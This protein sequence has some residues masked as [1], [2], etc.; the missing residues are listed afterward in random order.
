MELNDGLLMAVK[1]SIISIL[2]VMY[3]P[4][5]NV[6]IFTFGIVLADLTID[7]E[8]VKYL[9]AFITFLGSIGWMVYGVYS[10]VRGKR[11]KEKSIIELQKAEAELEKVRLQCKVEETQSKLAEHVIQVNHYEA[12]TEELASQREA[13]KAE[14]E[15]L[16]RMR[17]G[18]S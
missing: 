10:A 13:L 7:V 8:I 18:L 6:L 12:I 17:D 15:L 2:V 16:K 9:T 3:E 5:S 11:E 4:I 1:K 14:I